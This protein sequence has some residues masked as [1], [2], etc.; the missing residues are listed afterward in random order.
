V[1]YRATTA[2]GTDLG[3]SFDTVWVLTDGV[4]A[5]MPN[6]SGDGYQEAK[7]ADI[8]RFVV[9]EATAH[10]P[11]GAPTPKCPHPPEF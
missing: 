2:P 4:K 8:A 9:H 6:E 5:M 10:S 7:V 11:P 1:T 3:L